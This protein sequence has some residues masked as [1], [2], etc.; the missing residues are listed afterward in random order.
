MTKKKEITAQEVRYASDLS[1]LE[2][3]PE[4]ID[5]YSRQLAHILDYI[6]TLNELDTAATPPTSHPLENLKN[7]F[8]EDRPKPSLSLEDALR[9]APERKGDFFAVPKVIE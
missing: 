5:L 6:S 7:V 8:R 2:L 3:S 9:N 1:R 4:E